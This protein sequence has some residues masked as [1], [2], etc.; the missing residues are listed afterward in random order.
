MESIMLCTLGLFFL[1]CSFRIEG[2]KASDW[3]GTSISMPLMIYSKEILDVLMI[4][5]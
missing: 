1:A 2:G 3:S 5:N 4:F